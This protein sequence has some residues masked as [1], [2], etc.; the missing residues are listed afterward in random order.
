M[1]VIIKENYEEL[2]NLAARII[3]RIVQARPR[4]VLGL[5]T[6]GT[7]VGCYQELVRM[8]SEEDLDFSQ[9]VTFNLDELSLIHI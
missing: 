6:G 7:P 5:A 4:A 9:I 3:G 2:S 1:E 8:H